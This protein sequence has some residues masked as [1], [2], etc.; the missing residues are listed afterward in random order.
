MPP[1]VNDP[2]RQYTGQEPS[3]KGLGLCAHGESEGVR[4]RGRDGAMWEAVA[5]KSG[6]L[7]WRLSPKKTRKKTSATSATTG[8]KR[9]SKSSAP[10][11]APPARVSG[12][13]YVA[14]WDNY[15]T[16]CYV[17]Y[18]PSALS[19]G[20][21]AVEVYT[22]PP[23]TDP[24]DDARRGFY[25]HRVA[26]W[27]RARLFLGEASK[28]KKQQ[29]EPGAAVLISDLGK[30]SYVYIGNSDMYGFSTPGKAPVTEFYSH[31]D[32]ADR[33]T[34]PVAFTRTHAL[35]MLDR[36]AV[37]LSAIPERKL[38]KDRGDL[39]AWFYEHNNKPAGAV[40]M[41]TSTSTSAFI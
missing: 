24:G 23:D 11:P 31:G 16:P 29:Q 1:C 8:K 13:R 22:L 6:R 12:M 28:K 32:A 20:G 37:P 41:H 27:E 17:Y 9:G 38:H 19:A 26:S 21:G 5:D 35:F 39:Y 34:Y 40:Y 7:A 2:T 10:A 30:G 25:S 18:Q 14:I 36:L 33:V 3:P 15:Q 4:R